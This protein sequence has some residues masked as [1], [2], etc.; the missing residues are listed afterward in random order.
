[1]ENNPQ[2]LA[3]TPQSLSQFAE[4]GKTR[5]FEAI[6]GGD[7]KARKFGRKNLI[8]HEDAVAWLKSLPEA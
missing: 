7:L 3:Y 5:I 4:V 2:K 8:L 6:K 1:M